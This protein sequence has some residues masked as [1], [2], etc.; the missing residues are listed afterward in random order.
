MANTLTKYSKIF[1]IQAYVTFQSHHVVFI[2]V[3]FLTLSAFWFDSCKTS[4]TYLIVVTLA[5][6][7]KVVSFRYWW[8]IGNAY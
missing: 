3:P 8:M 5:N 4:H 2:D 1:L 6:I 7:S